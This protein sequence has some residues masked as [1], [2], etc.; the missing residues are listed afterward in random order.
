MRMN[1]ERILFSQGFGSR[2]ECRALIM[3]GAVTIDERCCDDPHADFE[4]TGLVFHVQGV[5]WQYCEKAYLIMHKPPGYECSHA[6]QHHPSVYGLLPAPL[7]ARG[8]QCIGR[9]DEDTTGLLLLSDD[10]AFI[11]RLSSPKRKIPKTYVAT[12]RHPVQRSQLEALL[13]GVLL[14]GETAPSIALSAVQRDERCV[15]M[16]LTE[17]KYHQVKRMIAAAGNRVEQL[18]REAIGSLTLPAT[19]APGQWR[20]LEAAEL[21]LL[22]G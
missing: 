21:G 19:L 14:R 8:V 1:L 4:P 22:T 18:H 13:R 15:E 11:H 10:G 7:V 12:T 17:G 16:V 2:R 5:R 20:W 6:P 3:R 9:L